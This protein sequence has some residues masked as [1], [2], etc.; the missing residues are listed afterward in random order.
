MKCFQAICLG[1]DPFMHKPIAAGSL[2]VIRLDS[3]GNVQLVSAN[4]VRFDGNG[5]AL[6]PYE[7]KEYFKLGHSAQA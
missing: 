3:Q 7:L 6:N 4:G 1:F 2:C 5:L